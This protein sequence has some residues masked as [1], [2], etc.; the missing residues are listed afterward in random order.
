MTTRKSGVDQQLIRDLAGILDET[1]LTEIEVEQGDMR[2][3][4]SRQAQQV[5][6]SALPPPP[7]PQQQV[8]T[9]E[10]SQQAAQ[11]SAADRA[12]NAV[13]APM[14]GTAYRSP[15]P[16]AKSFIEVGDKVR[17]G[18]TLLIIEAMKTMNQI[19]SPRSG[20]VIEILFEDTQP[21]EY[22]EPLV[23]IE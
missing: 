8:A 23:I 19:P 10:Q 3:R 1:N 14:V 7:Q 15:A 12:K 2:V 17:E 22:G 13:P 5:H 21:V 9:A 6:A 18:Q 4:V 20:T 11:P 16:G